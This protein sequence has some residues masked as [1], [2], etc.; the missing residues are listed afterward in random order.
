MF[1]NLS[2]TIV[3]DKV[4]NYQCFRCG[5]PS[6]LRR[7]F[8]FSLL[9]SVLLFSGLLFSCLLFSGFCFQANSEYRNIFFLNWQI[10][11]IKLILIQLSCQNKGIMG[12]YPFH[13]LATIV[14]NAIITL[15]F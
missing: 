2:F 14:I 12:Y 11:I 4:F 10:S 9:F 8:N 7:S 13:L 5:T 3:Y 6:L 15:P 1:H